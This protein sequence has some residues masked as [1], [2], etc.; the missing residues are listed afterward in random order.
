[1]MHHPGLFRNNNQVRRKM[2]YFEKTTGAVVIPIFKSIYMKRQIARHYLPVY[3]LVFIFFSISRLDGQTR[4]QERP[5]VLVIITDDQR[6]NTIRALG[7]PEI[8]TPTMDKLVNEGTAFTRAHIMG[9]LNG[10]ICQPSRAQLLSG[11]SL[12]HLHKDGQYIPP[13]DTTFPE[14]FRKNGYLTFGTGKWH[15]DKATFRRAFDTGDNILFAGM[16]PPA[17]GGQFRPRLNHFDSTGTYNE[18]F[19][20]DHFSSIYFADA[21]IEF[22]KN[23]KDSRQPFLMYVSFSSPH[24]PRTAPTWYGHSYAPSD[25]SLPVSFRPLPQFDNG[26]LYIRDEMLLPY[27]R[28][29]EAV[30]IELANYYSMV[31]EVDFQIG[32]IIDELKKTGK[33]DNTIIVFAGDNGLNVGDHGLLGKQN[34]YES[35]IRIPLIFSGKGIP[36]NRRIDQIVYLN[37]IYPTLCGLTGVPA[38]ESVESYS[39]TEAFGA[40]PKAFKGRDHAYFSYINI[41]RVLVKDGFKLI[42]YNVN[43]NHPVELFDLDKDPNELTNLAEDP[44]YKARVAQMTAQLKQ[45]MK[46]HND[47]CDM[48]QPNWGSFQKWS[49]DHVQTLNP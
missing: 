37:D 13:T 48:D 31:S 6:Y 23:Q 43:G 45:T 8:I 29:E 35:S 17:T 5:N 21:S 20:G 34:G 44:G 3:I 38:P 11:R 14:L 36:K 12:F 42:C 47:F 7:N 22:L 24:D 41:Q 33:Y 9:G 40:Q 2:F 15:Q 32:R 49:W 27:P 18:P 28:T 16:N 10:A 1:M 26:E 19:W 25:V 39:L 4:Q 46:S 30:R